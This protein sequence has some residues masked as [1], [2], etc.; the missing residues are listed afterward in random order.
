MRGQEYLKVWQEQDKNLSSPCFLCLLQWLKDT[1]MHPW[2]VLIISH[3]A[4]VSVQK[5]RSKMC[6][7]A[8]STRFLGGFFSLLE[9]FFAY[10][11]LK[12]C[13]VIW[14]VTKQEWDSSGR[15]RGDSKTHAFAIFLRLRFVTLRLKTRCLVSWDFHPGNRLSPLSGSPTL[16]ETPPPPKKDLHS[17][18]SSLLQIANVFLR[19]PFPFF[20]GV[21]NKVWELQSWRVQGNLLPTFRQPFAHFSNLFCQP[22]S[23]PLFWTW[24]PGTGLETWV[25]GF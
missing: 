9:V 15:K 4:N 5:R 13:L 14:S 7:F 3:H 23:K 1:N 18:L 2:N 19:S 25:N 22:L 6:G 20:H 21:T 8:S 12:W 24:T 16:T 17:N 10:C 11:Q